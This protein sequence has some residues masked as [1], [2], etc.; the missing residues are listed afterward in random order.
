MSFSP[1]S[2][3]RYLKSPI[4]TLLIG[5][6]PEETTLSAHLALLQ[7]SPWFTDA[8][9]DFTSDTPTEFR[10][11]SLPD[12]DIEAVG[13]FLEYL[14]T[15]EYSPRLIPSASG[16]PEDMVLEDAGEVDVDEGGDRLLKH[17]KV[18]TLAEKLRIPELKHLAHSKIHRIN[19]TAK[20][21]LRYAKFVYENTTRED[22]TIR[23]PIASFWA[24]RSH[25]LRHE[26][27]D[28]FKSMVLEFPQFAYDILSI[29]LDQKE[30]GKD[31]DKD[32]HR[33]H[34]RTNT[35]EDTEVPVGAAKT[36]R[37]GRKRPRTSTV[38]G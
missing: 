26:A 29:V 37:T 19:S 38:L 27:E 25:V 22:D 1:P 33:N 9:A 13:A 16:K 5:S 18:Y 4:I 2:I 17:A 14:Y 7:T 28:E 6:P 20:G 35:I 36:P 10:T 32:H 30:K 31:K 8:C 24:H 34:Q 12:D 15:K 23:K 11:V 3:D 21:E